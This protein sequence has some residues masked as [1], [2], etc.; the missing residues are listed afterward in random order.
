M[1]AALFTLS[2][3]EFNDGSCDAAYE[4]NELLTARDVFKLSCWF[5]VPLECVVIVLSLL[6][7]YNR[8]LCC[9]TV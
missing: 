7:L 9:E 2:R 6:R 8:F 1:A 4:L 5:S 3:L